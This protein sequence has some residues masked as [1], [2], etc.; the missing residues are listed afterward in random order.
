MKKH[1]LGDFGDKVLCKNKRTAN[2]RY[3]VDHSSYNV[4]FSETRHHFT[5]TV[6]SKKSVNIKLL[7][8]MLR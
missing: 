6:I 2:H 8:Q 5:V 4:T 1:I 7:K 3:T